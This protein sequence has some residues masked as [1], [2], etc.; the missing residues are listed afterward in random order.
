MLRSHQVWVVPLLY[1]LGLK[2]YLSW[3][4]DYS[5]LNQRAQPVE[6]G[7]DLLDSP[8]RDMK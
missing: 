7:I 5:H 8:I 2:S 1:V 3:W 4:R 6:V